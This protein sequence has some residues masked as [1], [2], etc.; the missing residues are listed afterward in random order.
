MGRANF[1][2]MLK[3]TKAFISSH[4]VDSGDTRVGIVVYNSQSVVHFYLDKYKTESDMFKAVDKIQYTAGSTNTSGAI[5]VI[6]KEMFSTLHGSRKDAAHIGIIITDGVSNIDYHRVKLESTKARLENITL[7]AVG[8]G[9]NNTQE[10]DDIAGKRE[11]RLTIKT[12]G[13]LEIELDVF[14]RS[15]CNGK[16]VLLP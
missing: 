8:V 5:K 4:D 2:L 10:L 16:E 9:L 12:F 14:F 13:D 3:A 6:R 11:H 1:S 7:L 15:L